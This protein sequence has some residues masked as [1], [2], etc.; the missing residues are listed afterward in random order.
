MNIEPLICKN[1]AGTI[2]RKS[3]ICEYCGTHYK[4][5][6]EELMPLRIEHFSSPVRVFKT[7][8]AVSDEL[9]HSGISPDAIADHV[10]CNMRD[11][12]AKAI[13]ECMEMETHF[14]PKTMQQIFT[15][16][17]RIVEPDFRFS[18]YVRGGF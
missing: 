3:M 18:N 10:M 1:C 12:L 15:A 11:Q 2:N 17:I 5:E 4:M 8:H 6:H 14:E 16:K 13:A 7:Q 9:M